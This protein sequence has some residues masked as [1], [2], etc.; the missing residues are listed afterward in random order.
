LGGSKVTDKIE[1]ILNM[2][3]VADEIIIGGGMSNPF[4]RQFGG[5]KL[6]STQVDMPADPN[7]LQR[8]MDKAKERG[9]KIHLPVDG[10]CAQAY[11]ATAPT[12]ICENKD[13]P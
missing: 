12:I 2:L 7:S 11:S 5:F 1:L 10:V 3:N 8:I 9:V 6:G 13:V 4:L